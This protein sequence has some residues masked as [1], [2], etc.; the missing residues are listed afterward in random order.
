MFRQRTHRL[1]T[2]H[3]PVPWQERLTGRDLASVAGCLEV[4][5]ETFLHTGDS[6]DDDPEIYNIEY[7]VTIMPPEPE[8]NVVSCEDSDSDSNEANPGD[9]HH[10]PPQILTAPAGDKEPYLDFLWELV[11]E[12]IPTHGAVNIFFI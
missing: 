8:H 2:S 6:S 1:L 5:D 12:M 7:D 4:E 9:I 10:L 3:E 11:L